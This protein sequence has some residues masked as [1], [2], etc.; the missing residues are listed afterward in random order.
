[1][2][3]AI[4]SGKEW[5][6]ELCNKKKSG[7]L[8]WES[9]SISPIKN[10]EGITTNYVALKEDITDKKL[11]D[12]KLKHMMA[13][14]QRSNKELEQFAYVASHDLQE[15]LRMVASYMRLLHRRYSDKLDND[16]NDF[17][18]YAVDGSKRM[19]ELIRDL[20][21]Y[22]RVGSLGREFEPIDIKTVL[23]RSVRNLEMS[24]KESGA[25]VTH[26]SMPA[27]F[28]DGI[29]ITQLFQNLISNAIKYCKEAPPRIHVSAKQNKKAVTFSVSDNGI[30]VDPQYYERIF[31]IF[32][33]LHGKG[34]YS[35]TGIGLAICKK[36]VERHDGK[37]WVESLPGGGS[38][39]Y[40]TI[41]TK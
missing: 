5:R 15:P 23:D 18:N 9:A 35:G 11:A 40:F 32:Q 8:F 38:T 22:S 27:M 6:G 12:E 21:A 28:A 20:L 25:V 36:I 29:Q 30:G 10:P 17:I 31:I 13:D 19:Q 34:E 24:I 39:F 7:K 4:T 41:P 14:I 37:I 3:E 26:D 16:A 2:W 1:L 33:R